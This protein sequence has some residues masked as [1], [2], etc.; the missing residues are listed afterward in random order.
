VPTAYRDGGRR[1]R[2]TSIDVQG[3]RAEDDDERRRN[4]RLSE[5][6]CRRAAGNAGACRRRWTQS[7]ASGMELRASGTERPAE[8]SA[9][10]AD[11]LAGRRGGGIPGHGGRRAGEENALAALGKG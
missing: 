5:W 3:C 4:T 9:E 10:I 8:A 1:Q 7:L 2:L 11:V 6:S